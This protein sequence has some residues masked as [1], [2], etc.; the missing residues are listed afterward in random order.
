MFQLYSQIYNILFRLA[1]NSLRFPAAVG[2]RAAHR[3]RR[4][5]SC[6][7]GTSSG[8]QVASE[9]ASLHLW[10]IG[11][12]TGRGG[13]GLPA[14]VG[15]WAAHRLR[16]RGLP[17]TCGTSSGTQVAAEGAFLRLWDIERH[18]GRGG[19]GLPAPVGHRTAHRSRRRGPS[20]TCGTLGG[21][22][23]AAE[24]MEMAV[25]GMEMT[26]EGVAGCGVRNFMYIYQDKG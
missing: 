16:L 4:G 8:T 25:E 12:H 21:T 23:G 20:C 6:T 15:H 14:P 3:S 9:G 19:G 10:S 13:G 26:A 22:H 7:C 1:N 17:C 11:R 2:H 24:G 18:T 5:P